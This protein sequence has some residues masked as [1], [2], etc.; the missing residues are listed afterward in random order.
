M[1]DHRG[2]E[3]SFSIKNAERDCGDAIETQSR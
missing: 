3:P 1:G 2:F